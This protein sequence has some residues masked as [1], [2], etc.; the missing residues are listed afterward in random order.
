VFSQLERTVAGLSHAARILDIPIV[1]GNDS[2]YNESEEFHTA[3]IPTPSI[4]MVGILQD[5][6]TVAPAVFQEKGDIVMMIGETYPEYGGSE[7]AEIFEIGGA[8]PLPRET[9]KTTIDAL[10]K[11]VETGNITAAS[12]IS[13]G[14]IIAA[15]GKMC[16]HV[17]AEVNLSSCLDDQNELFSESPGRAILTVTPRLLNSISAVLDAHDVP[18]AAIGTVGGGSLSVTVGDSQL[19]LSLETI[20]RSHNT[21]N[22]IM[23]A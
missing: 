9:I 1:G 13:R 6:S 11:V 8:V 20:E 3:I 15:L 10:V 23:I 7:Y 18:Y 5:I 19:T 14:G 12:D 2:L 4:G 16:K 21:L 17:G 22:E